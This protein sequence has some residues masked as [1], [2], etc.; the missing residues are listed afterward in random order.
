M[1]KWKWIGLAALAF[2]LW[3]W[4]RKHKADMADQ[5]ARQGRIAR[6]PLY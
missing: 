3:W 4:W 2:A 6:E 5:A 1:S